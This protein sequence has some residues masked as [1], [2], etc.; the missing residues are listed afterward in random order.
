MAC[1]CPF[2]SDLFALIIL[3]DYDKLWAQEISDT[4]IM[5]GPYF[6]WTI[7]DVAMIP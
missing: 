2:K 7:L 4:Y 3:G 1:S 5:F 6:I